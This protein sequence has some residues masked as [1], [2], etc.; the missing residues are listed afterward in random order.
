MDMEIVRQASTNVVGAPMEDRPEPPAMWQKF[1]QAEPVVA[2]IL[3][4]SRAE[5]DKTD[6]SLLRKLAGLEADKVV[7]EFENSQDKSPEELEKRVDQARRNVMVKMG[8]PAV[9]NF[10]RPLPVIKPSDIKKS[11]EEDKREFGSTFFEKKML[12][13]Q[14]GR[15]GVNWD[16]Q[17]RRMG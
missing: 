10:P 2:G 13:V 17:L 14:G 3:P 9:G 6:N 12:P 11:I 4:D 5:V 15:V 8:E 1:S 7:N 16:S